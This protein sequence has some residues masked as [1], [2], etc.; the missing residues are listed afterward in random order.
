[1]ALIIK[2]VEGR[3]GRR[4]S[5]RDVERL[6]RYIRHC[7]PGDSGEKVS[8]G[9]DGSMN[10]EGAET[11]EEQLLLMK[12]IMRENTRPSRP[13]LH[14]IISWEATDPLPTPAQ[15]RAVVGTLMDAVGL[16]G[17]MA[18]WSAHENTRHWHVHLA[19]CRL[20]P[21]TA[22]QRRMPYDELA[23]MKAKAACDTALKIGS[24]VRDVFKVK[25]GAKVVQAGGRFMVED[26][27]IVSDT[28][29]LR[30][31]EQALPQGAADAEH[32]DGVMSAITFA[33]KTLWPKL[34]AAKEA[35][36]WQQ[37]HVALA[38][39]GCRI[40]IAGGGLIV[41]VGSERVKASQL[42]RACSRKALETAMG[43]Y[44][45]APAEL[46]L[47]PA[48]ALGGAP[49]K[50]KKK[51]KKSAEVPAPEPVASP[52]LTAEA[53]LQ[54]GPE[55]TV[56]AVLPVPGMPRA[57]QVSWRE[58][59]TWL[60]EEA[61]R[62]RR[63]AE[64]RR[65]ERTA[66]TAKA[67]SE[68]RQAVAQIAM[69]AR[70]D[71]RRLR[72]GAREALQKALYWR[73]CRHADA[74][75]RRPA[76]E[77]MPLPGFADWLERIRQRPDLAALWRRRGGAPKPIGGAGDR[78]HASALA[79]TRTRPARSVWLTASRRAGQAWP[80]AGRR[81]E[82]ASACR[83]QDMQKARTLAAGAE[84]FAVARR[85]RAGSMPV[86]PEPKM[87]NLDVHLERTPEVR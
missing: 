57:L 25:K 7:R 32:R 20:D 75:A 78:L 54:E 52:S 6:G 65:T 3:R 70:T 72:R 43:P 51:P 46:T 24:N 53:I 45:A 31:G 12:N 55:P 66:A 86:E 26:E 64:T 1:M 9:Y 49:K 5:E 73:A 42:S 17:C 23:A 15:V 40:E 16:R 27:A 2:K 77:P 13:V 58:Y 68:A 34:Q 8:P 56:Q 39:E 67:R 50:R 59:Q 87:K 79:R 60:A 30:H 84:L 11:L 35:K 36:S 48:P 74:E 61:E 4:Q 63:Q 80:K 71:G 37:A 22:K 38:S 19:V 33:R 81:T 62:R 14:Y 76:A 85:L 29:R 10:L 82:H 47:A 18:L 83:Q 41:W 69:L 21:E 28:A 44:E